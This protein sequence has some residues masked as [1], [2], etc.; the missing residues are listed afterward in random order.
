MPI[1]FSVLASGSRGNAS[2]LQVDGSGL[3]IDLGLGLR[4]LTQRLESIGERWETIAGAMLTHTHRDHVCDATL[5]CLARQGIP[6]LCHEGHQT[7]LAGRP[8]FEALQ[9]SKLVRTFDDRPFL[10]AR[11]VWAESIP[12]RHSGPTFGFRLEARGGR[13]ERPVAIGY[14]TDTGSWSD[15]MA[16]ALADVDLLGLEFNHDV[17][18]QRES[19]RAW[20]LIARNLGD[21]G[22]LSN[23]QGADFLSALLDRS[24]AGALREVVLLHLSQQCNRPEI[25]LKA[26][27]SALRTA[28]RRSRVQAARQGSALKVI[29]VQ[30]GRRRQ[31]VPRSRQPAEPVGFP[32]EL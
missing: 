23:E 26:A 25:A 22:H 9:S 12:V 31:V 1:Q 10:A 2:L 20:P 15:L 27:R 21:Y 24:H 28:G 3:L 17:K 18:L 6:L 14:L 8:G 29:Q 16:D 32:W 11:G 30:S 7:T 19:G 4:A 5:R 13:R